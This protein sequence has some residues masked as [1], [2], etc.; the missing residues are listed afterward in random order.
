V[1]VLAIEP[2]ETSG[3]YR[4]RAEVAVAQLETGIAARDRKMRE[5]FD[6][7]HYRASRR[8]SRTSN[9]TRCARGARRARVPAPIHG[10]ERAV[11]PEVSDWS[12]VPGRSAHFRA[13]FD[14][15][16][17][18]FGLEAPVAMGFVRVQDRVHVTVDVDLTARAPA[19]PPHAA[20]RSA[21]LLSVRDADRVRRLRASRPL[22]RARRALARALG[23]V[24]GRFR[25]SRRLEQIHRNVSV[26]RRH[27]ALAIE[28]YRTLRGFGTRTPR[29][30]AAGSTSASAQSATR[31]RERSSRPRTSTTS[32]RSRSRGSRRRRSTRGS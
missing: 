7:E 6:A 27:L 12:E 13:A 23:A 2:P 28:E 21:G 29:S 5:M 3:A 30:S 24:A 11:T 25:N 18:E 9:R 15:S 22:L 16:L 10:V 14:V 8:A 4:A 1:R 17:G 19:P 20:L 32:S 26:G 31:S